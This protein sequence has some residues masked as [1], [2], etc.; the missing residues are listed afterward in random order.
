MPQVVCFAVGADLITMAVWLALGEP[1]QAIERTVT[2]LVI[3]CPHALGL[4]I[5]LVI[6]I[7]TGLAA[8]LG[9]PALLRDLKVAE[10]EVLADKVSAWKWRGAAVLYVVREDKVRARCRWVRSG[11]S[12][13]TPWPSCT[14]SAGGW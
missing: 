3:A 12:P 9:G 1:D 6:A 13:T 14:A 2:V 5:P 10:P 7:A 8:H 4:A 11:P